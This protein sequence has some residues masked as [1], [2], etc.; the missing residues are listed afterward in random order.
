MAGMPATADHGVM[1][2]ERPMGPEPQTTS[3]RQR[4]TDGVRRF[5]ASTG[6]DGMSAAPI[7]MRK[8]STYIAGFVV[9]IVVLALGAGVAFANVPEDATAAQPWVAS[10]YED[11]AP[12][13]TVTLTGGNWQPGES[14]NIFVDDDLT[15]T[16]THDSD[17]DPVADENGAFTYSFDLPSWFVATYT[18]HATGELSGSAMTTF[19]D[20]TLPQRGC[21]DPGAGNPIVVDTFSDE[22][23]GAAGGTNAQKEAGPCSLREAIN[24]ANGDAAADT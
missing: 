2:D 14:V 1:A 10:E 17:P 16:W 21:A 13:A 15:K 19:T 4:V 11:Y 22:F 3:N 9:A 12:G 7:N 5:F 6:G 23:N 24:A 20:A 18:V 8:L